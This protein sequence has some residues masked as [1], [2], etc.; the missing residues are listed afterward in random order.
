MTHDK[1]EE[2]HFLKVLKD[3][4]NSSQKNFFMDELTDA[5]R[6]GKMNPQRAKDLFFIFRGKEYIHDEDDPNALH[7]GTKLYFISDAGKWYYQSLLNEKENE[8]LEGAIKKQTISNTTFTKNVTYFSLGV[9]LVVGIIPLIIFFIERGE[10]KKTQVIIPEIKEILQEQ[11]DL[12]ESVQD[13]S[14]AIHYADT[15]KKKVKIVK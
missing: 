4:T 6:T 7:P 8:D 10:V 11:R 1:L 2:L 9:A 12:K 5:V 14:S 3:R 13:I 15:A